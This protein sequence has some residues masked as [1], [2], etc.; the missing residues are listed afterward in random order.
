MCVW[1]G[2]AAATLTI[3]SNSTVQQNE[4]ACLDNVKM[5]L[6]TGGVWDQIGASGND[7]Q[8]VDCTGPNACEV[9]PTGQYWAHSATDLQWGLNNAFTAAAFLVSG[10]YNY[11]SAIPSVPGGTTDYN[12]GGTTG[13]YATL[14]VIKTTA[15][16]GTVAVGGAPA[17]MVA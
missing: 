5:L 1:T 15:V 4:A 16:A 9:A 3:Q 8:Y 2:A 13:A 12:V 10:Q 14:P 17:A 11:S 7:I 6:Q